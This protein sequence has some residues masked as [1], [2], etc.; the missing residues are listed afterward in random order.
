MV[1]VAA[2]AGVDIQSTAL[3]LTNSHTLIFIIAFT[4]AGAIIGQPAHV[5]NQ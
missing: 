2:A 3:T 5:V 4:F 1:V